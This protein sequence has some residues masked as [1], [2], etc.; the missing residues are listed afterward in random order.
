ME[1]LE[2]RPDIIIE[3]TILSRFNQVFDDTTLFHYFV[4]QPEIILAIYDKYMK[5]K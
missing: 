2:M 1:K 3:S 4:E 5:A